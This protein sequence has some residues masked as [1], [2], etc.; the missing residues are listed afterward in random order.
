MLSRNI[1]ACLTQGNYASEFARHGLATNAEQ[2]RDP[3]K[4][5]LDPSLTEPPR[6]LREEELH[7]LLGM[8]RDVHKLLFDGA[9]YAHLDVHGHPYTGASSSSS[10]S[11][12]AASSSAVVPKAYGTP[13]PFFKK[14]KIPPL[15]K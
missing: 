1:D 6:K 15:K 3:I 7:E 11:G 4:E 13:M 14:L 2:L 12:S 8:K 10:S 5:I 9:R